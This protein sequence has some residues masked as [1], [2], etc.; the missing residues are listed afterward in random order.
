MQ[1][2]SVYS[3]VCNYSA[4]LDHRKKLVGVVEWVVKSLN[5]VQYVYC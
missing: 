3:L 2:A 5:M 4:P 1:P